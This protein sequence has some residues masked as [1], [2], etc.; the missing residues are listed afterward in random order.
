MLCRSSDA[1]VERPRS[2][3]HKTIRNLKSLLA[4][5]KSKAARLEHMVAATPGPHPLEEYF[6]WCRR[7]ER[8]VF[9]TCGPVLKLTHGR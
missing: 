4:K 1:L 8:K 7:N 5:E 6:V 3:Y 2:R 9:D